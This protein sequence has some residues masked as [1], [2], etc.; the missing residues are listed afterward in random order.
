MRE[1]TACVPAEKAGLSL[2]SFLKKQW[3]FSDSLLSHLKFMP[4]SV[5]VN[6]ASAKMRDVLPG[7]ACVTVRMEETAAHPVRPV[8]VPLSV[9]WEDEDLLI[10]DKPA[11]M[12]VHELLAV[13]GLHHGLYGPG[14]A[15]EF[16]D[17]VFEIHRS[18]S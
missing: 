6:G 14:V 4:G 17:G 11:G 8:A 7:G 3:G 13:L 16:L 5:T 9:L 10:L 12:A 18:T 1:L 15:F 2:H